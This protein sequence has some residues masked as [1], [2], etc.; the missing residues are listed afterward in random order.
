MRLDRQELE[1]LDKQYR[2]ALI[3]SISGLRPA[4][5]VGTAG[6]DGQTNL[7]IFNSLVHIGA[8]PPLLGLVFRPDSVERHTLSNLRA[9]GSYTI[10]HVCEPF[11]KAAHQ[12]SARY[13][14]DV[15]EFTAVGLTEHW[16]DDVQAPFVA[17]AHVRMALELREELPVQANGTYLVV[18]E[19]LSIDVPDEAVRASGIFDPATAGSLAVAGL[20]AYFRAEPIA[21]LPYAKATTP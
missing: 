12:T 18:G 4:V 5:L 14:G 3:N 11:L 21:E 13:P 10:N 9:T 8:S 20:N 19:I 7:A 1:G 17:E 16:E 15:S 6:P 2:V